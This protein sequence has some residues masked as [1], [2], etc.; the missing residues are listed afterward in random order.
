MGQARVHML[1]G[2]LDLAVEWGL[3]AADMD[4]N[5]IGLSQSLLWT[6]VTLD[7]DELIAILRHRVEAADPDS[8]S[9]L[10]MDSISAASRGNFRGALEQ[11][12]GQRSA[13]GDLPWI[14]AIEGYNYAGL[15]DATSARAAFEAYN[16]DYFSPATWRRAIESNPGDACH[17]AWMLMNTGEADRGEQ[18]LR[19]TLHYMEVEL[20]QYVDY[21]KELVSGIGYCYLLNG[22][23]ESVLT[24]VEARFEHRRINQWFWYKVI[25]QWAPVLREPRFEAVD[26]QVQAMLAEQRE[27]LRLSGVLGAG[28]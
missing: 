3:R 5:N 21:P 9:L 23:M 25:P 27:N 1:R 26:R 18:L 16:A 12:G 6:A 14:S 19:E 17:A 11:L 22:D 28:P 4:P 20:P 15:G 7:D 2:R 13:Y 10:G 24:V 8:V